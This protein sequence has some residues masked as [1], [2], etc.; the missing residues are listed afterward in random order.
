[1]ADQRTPT[2][3]AFVVYTGLRLL[4]FAVPFL[5]IWALSGNPSLSAVVAAVVGLCVSFVLLDR[6]RGAVAG[7]L[8]ERL[9]RRASTSDESIE[10]RALDGDA[11][12]AGPESDDAQTASAAARPKP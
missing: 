9:G 3:G 4:C 2:A 7:I 12:S 8:D 6:Q 1:M 11:A 10:D 5:V